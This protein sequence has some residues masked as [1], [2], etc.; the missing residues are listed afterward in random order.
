MGKVAQSRT[1]FTVRLNTSEDQAL[2]DWLGQFADSQNMTRLIRTALY[3]VSGLN[4]P[5]SLAAFQLELPQ[6]APPQ[7]A[8]S[9]TLDTSASDALNKILSEL[10][11]LKQAVKSPTITLPMERAETGGG[12]DMSGPRRKVTRPGPAET[13]TAPAEPAF[14]PEDSAALFLA[15]MR[16]FSGN[17][18]PDQK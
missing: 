5:P 15:S 12:I 1:A 4:V 18:R 11:A 17:K 6:V 14:S 9:Q 3:A 8:Q 7:T 10:A 16:G 2:A 13:P